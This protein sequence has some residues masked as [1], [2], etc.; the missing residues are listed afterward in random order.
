M[1]R[2]EKRANKKVIEWSRRQA[3]LHASHQARVA[4]AVRYDLAEYIK[5]LAEE[6]AMLLK[7]FTRRWVENAGRW[8]KNHAYDPDHYCIKQFW[9]QTASW[10]DSGY[11][12]ECHF[13]RVLQPCCDIP[14]IAAPPP[15]SLA[16]MSHPTAAAQR[17]I[18]KTIMFAQ[19]CGLGSGNCRCGKSGPTATKCMTCGDYFM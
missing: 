10:R 1:T 7:E 9:H 4:L 11:Q 5:Q 16:P 13:C 8:A 2:G 12:V 15:S 17:M 6:R 3:S 19:K 18:Y 14:S